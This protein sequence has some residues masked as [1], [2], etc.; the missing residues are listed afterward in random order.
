MQ[1]KAVQLA[2]QLRDRRPDGGPGPSEPPAE[3]E[4]LLR[5]LA[6]GH[7]TFLGYREYDLEDGPDGMALRAV[8]GT[9]LGI[10]RHDREGSS[11]FAALPPE[12]RARARD[13][14]LLILT[15]ANSRSTVHRPSYLDYVAVKRLDERAARWSGEYRFLG[16]YTHD[17]YTE[18]ITRIPVL[19]RKLTEVLAA[20]GIA[21]DSHDG[22]DVAEFLESYPREELFQTPVAQ[23]GRVAEGVLR[24][25][26]RTQ[27][28]LFLRKDVY[29]RYM[30]CLVYLPRDRYTTQVRLRTSRRSCARRSAAARSTTARWSASRRW[31]GCTSWC[32]PSAGRV[33]PD[34]DA[35]ELEA[36]VAAAV[37]SWDDDLAEEA[38][39]QLGEERGR[40]RCSADVRRRV[41]SRRPTRPTC[42]PCRGRRPGQD[43]AA[44]R[45]RREHR[46][47]HVGVRGLRG[48]GADRRRPSE[49]RASRQR[50]AARVWRLTIYRTGSPITLTDVLPRLQHMGVEVVDEH[51]Y[52]FAAAEP[53]WIYDFGLRRSARPRPRR[54]RGSPSSARVGQGAAPGCPGRAV[55]RRHRGRRVQRAGARR[56]PDLAAGG[57]AARLRQVPAPG[58]QHVQPELHRAACCAPT[59][60]SPGCWSGCSSPGSTRT[61]RRGEAERSEAIIEE[62]RGELDEVASLDEDRI[63]RAYLGPDPGDAADQLLRRAG[64]PAAA[65]PVPGGQARRGAGARPARAAA[66]VRDV[67]LL[68]PVRGRAPAVRRRR[69]RRAALVG[70]A[71]GLPHRDPRPGQGAGGQ[72]LGHRPVRRQG[73]LRLQAAARPR[74][75]RGLPG[76]GAR[77]LPQLHQRD[78]GRD[79]QPRGRRRWC[80]PRGWSATTA[81]TPTSWSPPTRARRRSPTPP[82]RSR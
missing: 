13:P 14:Q 24:L 41:R 46:V 12:V 58:G 28:R 37:R 25:R 39:R 50:T 30:S 6:D 71:G 79:R 8:P 64:A 38:V 15:K 66:E 49:R 57:R 17:A 18:S 78:A 22:Q 53:F 67:R 82:T 81:T 27:T 10:L 9:G 47:R 36:Q 74:R 45:V 62:I 44:A 3:V 2:E 77:L 4:A 20:T 1:A 61:G 21:A 26:E 31:P 11:S 16:L 60:P 48:R 52:E 33:L 23:L 40:T 19:R 34:V 7:F 42:R 29:G 72:E 63:L 54:A 43:P 68:A 73:R 65:G 70:P 51:P 35:A 69:P 56:A 5:W 75:P 76:R 55:A 59:S 80:R 32:G